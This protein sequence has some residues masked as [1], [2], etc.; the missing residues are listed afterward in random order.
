MEQK[1]PNIVK[2]LYTNKNEKRSFI[3]S[4]VGD[5][6]VFLLGVSLSFLNSRESPMASCWCDGSRDDALKTMGDGCAK[7]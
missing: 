4:M 1:L 7:M 3:L 5:V 6:F 2:Q